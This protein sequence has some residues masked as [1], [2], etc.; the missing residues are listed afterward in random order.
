MTGTRSSDDSTVVLRGGTLV[1][2][3]PPALRRGDL[4]IQ[5]GHIAAPDVAEVSTATEID[6]SGCLVM[7][8][9]V[10]GHGHLY[11][12]LATGMPGPDTSPTCF[13]EILERVWWRLD[14]ALDEASLRASA[15]VGAIGAIRCGTTSIIDH[16]AS[17]SF[18]DGS[19]DAIAEALDEV[20]LRSVLC[21]EV[22]DRGG[23]ERRDAGLRENER[24]LRKEMPFARGLVGGHASFTMSE[25]TLEACVD[26]A[27]KVGSGLHVHLAEDAADQRDS[28]EKFGLPVADRLS[29][30]EA[31]G[32]RTLVVHGVHLNADERAIVANAPCW[33]AHNP[34]SN[35]NNSVG[36]AAPMGLSDRLILGTDGIGADMFAES[37]HAFF[38]AREHELSADAAQILAWLT[39][40]ADFMSDLFG[41]SIGRL[42]VGSVGDVIVL[43]A[44]LP[45]PLSA[46]NLPWY[47]MFGFSSRLVRD[48]VMGGR[49]VLRDRVITTVDEGKI[50]ASAREQAQTLWSRM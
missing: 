39:R 48:V 26:L 45:T 15:L 1:D 4:V 12:A 9:L 34:R 8:G 49:V 37:Q 7:P 19:L 44:Q 38:R 42:E 6:C 31:L 10:C 17:P 50:L 36:Y 13:T 25:E 24:F 35:M 16:H 46:G 18:I 33:V 29:R 28:K 2:L 14:E 41:Q 5:G 27:R 21:Y 3:S 47:W 43:D 20:G 22:T 11:S 30:A 40:G 23:M 32:A